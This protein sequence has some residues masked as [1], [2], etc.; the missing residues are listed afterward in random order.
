MASL[1]LNL[2]ATFSQSRPL[3]IGDTLPPITLKNVYNHPVSEIQLSGYS[4]KLIILDLWGSYCGA[5]IT[6][7]P[8][9]QKLQEKFGDRIQVILV[10]AHTHLTGD[11]MPRTQRIFDR[12]RKNAGISMNL[13]V[14]FS[15]PQLDALFP[16][17]ILPHQV[18]IGPDGIVKAITGPDQV[19]E[20]NIRAVLENRPVNL[21]MKQEL[22]SF[23]SR[24]PLFIRGNG[25]DGSATRYRSLL[26]GYI[27]GLG[28]V[29]GSRMVG[30][31]LCGVYATN[32]SRLGLAKMAW[33]ELAEVHQNRMIFRSTDSLWNCT[34]EH[35]AS[36]NHLYC[37]DLLTPPA[38]ETAIREWMRQD[39]VRYFNLSWHRQSILTECL[40]LTGF[41]KKWK[42]STDLN[43]DPTTLK[44]FIQGYPVSFV[45]DRLNELSTIPFINETT[46][47][48]PVRI[49]LPFELTDIEGL[50]RAFK[51]AGL[52]LRRE[53]REIEVV[54]LSD[55]TMY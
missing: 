18:W 36:A 52:T 35:P 50:V 21:R 43:I 13:P 12:V 41:S 6:L 40:V 20:A 48:S 10:N 5:C 37:Y 19:T 8:H 49:D 34:I 33:P 28:T 25:G 39:I 22:M 23:D 11:D 17:K 45:L 30:D 47:T 9:L 2:A 55:G 38:S 32:A 26:T 4:G 54:V 44:K 27:D 1:C 42:G 24:S 14:S 51:K 3:T 15:N 31:S 53:K 16:F 29:V 46:G 7:F